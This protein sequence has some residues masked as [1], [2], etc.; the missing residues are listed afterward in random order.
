MQRRGFLRSVIAAAIAP[1]LP[2]AAATTLVVGPS[3][4]CGVNWDR[5]ATAYC[6]H[7]WITN[8]PPEWVDDPSMYGMHP[9]PGG[10]DSEAAA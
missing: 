8:V 3:P 1:A 7:L 2:P 10:M 5:S 4:W 9:Y 6:S